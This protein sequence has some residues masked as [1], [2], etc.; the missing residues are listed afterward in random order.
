MNRAYV[1]LGLAMGIGEFLVAL[2]IAL[3]PA[4]LATAL[5]W[6][7]VLFLPSGLFVYGLIAGLPTRAAKYFRLT[8]RP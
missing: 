1:A 3:P 6:L 4:N 8:P 2:V 5:L 7:L